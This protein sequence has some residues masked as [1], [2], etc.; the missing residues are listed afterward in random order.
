MWF[1]CLCTALM[2]EGHQGLRDTAPALQ[3][4]GFLLKPWDAGNPIYFQIHSVCFVQFQ[5]LSRNLVNNLS[6]LSPTARTHHF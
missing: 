4:A 2:F 3:T 6:N 5:Q 1:A